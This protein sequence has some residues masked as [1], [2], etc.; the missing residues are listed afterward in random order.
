MCWRFLF[1]ETV[2]SLR[3]QPIKR[4]QLPSQKLKAKPSF[5]KPASA[6][7]APGNTTAATTSSTRPQ[8][9][10]TLA[11]WA[12]TA[13]DDD[14]NGFYGQEKRQRGGR[15]KRK[16][17]RD[18]PEFITNWDDI[19]DPSRPNNYEEYKRSDEKIR[20]MREWKDRLYAHRM[21]RR[22]SNDYD[23]DEESPPPRNRKL[24]IQS[25]S[26]AV[27]LLMCYRTIRPSFI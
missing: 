21:A 22:R 20:E 19:Y 18:G 12:S 8:V 13:D 17:N 1:H 2:A 7:A 10:S 11:D 3:F 4:P 16:K 23:S 5:P 25:S 9:K 26:V 27:T 6:P 14:V 15:K 24:Y